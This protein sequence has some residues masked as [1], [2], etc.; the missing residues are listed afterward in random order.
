VDWLFVNSAVLDGLIALLFLYMAY[1]A[2]E[3]YQSTRN[4]NLKLLSAASL[5]GASVQA[6]YVV[7]EVQRGYPTPYDIP[8]GDLLQL[9]VLVFFVWVLSKL[10]DSETRFRELA[11]LL[12]EIVY[13]A[14][15]K[16]KLTFLNRVGFTSTGYSEQEIREGLSAFQMISPEDRERAIENVRRI[17]AGETYSPSEYTILRKDG[18]TFPAIIHSSATTREGK[19]VSLKGIVV[20]ITERKRMEEALLRSQRFA[21][22]GELAAMVGHDLRNP[23]T[24]IASAEYY[25]KKKER[26]RLSSKAQE[27]LRLIAQSV[28]RSNKIITDLLDYSREPVL[29]YVETDAKSITEDALAQ[30]KIPRNVRVV[31]STKKQPKITVDADKMQRV[32]VNVVRNAVEAM[33][34]GGTLTIVSTR[35]N[36][37]LRIAFK[38]TG[39]GM[40]KETIEKVWSPLFTTKPSGIGLGL[41]I[42]KRLVEAHGGSVIVESEPGKGSTF[43]V[44]IPIKPEPQTTSATAT[45]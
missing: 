35:T 21:T 28:E 30:V 33:P 39:E 45:L 9:V 11:D 27:M 25:L 22:I 31:D 36:S 3:G 13:E 12:P 18:S 38:D 24:A 26:S 37:H 10:V 15:N 2:W 34:T 43:T 14:D 7:I 8:L 6:A 17:L 40:T 5:L 1:S 19:A 42:V 29:Q 41:P 32:F 23:L 20:D 16:G 4:P 44:T